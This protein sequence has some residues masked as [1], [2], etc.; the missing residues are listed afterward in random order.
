LLDQK[1]ALICRFWSIY[2]VEDGKLLLIYNNTALTLL[3]SRRPTPAH[4]VPNG[5][6]ESQLDGS[7]TQCRRHSLVLGLN[8]ED[9]PRGYPRLAALVTVVS[10]FTIAKRFD[11]LHM[12]NLQYLQDTIAEIGERLAALDESE[13]CQTFLSSRRH[14]GNK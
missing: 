1:V 13:T 9:H 10:Q 5:G 11:M 8:V 12:R 7:L 3:F 6:I 4:H 14:D 2:R